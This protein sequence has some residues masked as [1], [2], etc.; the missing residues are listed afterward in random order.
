MKQGMCEIP[1]EENSFWAKWLTLQ[2]ALFKRCMAITEQYHDAED[3]LS[4]VMYKAYQK[5]P[6][7]EKS[8]KH[9]ENWLG[10]LA[11]NMAI[12]IQRRKQKVIHTNPT[13]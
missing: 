6:S 10:L 3:L 8:L 12:D 4:D 2:N 13:L 11:K 7:E 1:V 9:F 5:A